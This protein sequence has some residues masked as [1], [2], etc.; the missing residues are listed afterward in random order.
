MMRM[1]IFRGAWAISLLLVCVPPEVISR[2]YE[3]YPGI[4]VYGG[5]PGTNIVEGN[6]IWNAGEGIQV[7]SD[8]VVRNNIIF[9]CEATGITAAPH[10]AMPAVRNVTIVNNTIFNAPVGVR[11]RWAKSTNA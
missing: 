8:A 9:N 1:R 5:G 10:G 3:S 6:V 7:V 11:M 2:T 4:F